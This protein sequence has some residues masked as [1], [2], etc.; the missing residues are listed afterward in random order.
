MNSN[1]SA[2]LELHWGWHLFLSLERLASTP[3]PIAASVFDGCDANKALANASIISSW[4]THLLATLMH[5]PWPLAAHASCLITYVA[6]SFD[7]A[8]GRRYRARKMCVGSPS[9]KFKYSMGSQAEWW[10]VKRSHGGFDLFVDRL[11]LRCRLLLTCSVNSL[12]IVPLDVGYCTLHSIYL[13]LSDYI[14]LIR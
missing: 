6:I 2:T 11:V 9:H 4:S 8:R 5:H 7:N 10:V 14:S 3:A 1:R 12:I 13:S